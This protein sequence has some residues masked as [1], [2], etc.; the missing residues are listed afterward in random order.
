MHLCLNYKRK[1]KLNYFLLI[2]T[3][4]AQYLLYLVLNI[5][6][7]TIL[8]KID[9]SN[10]EILF[11]EQLLGRME[12]WIRSTSHF[13]GIF[14]MEL[15]K[16]TP[17]ELREEVRKQTP[18][19]SMGDQLEIKRKCSILLFYELSTDDRITLSEL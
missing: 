2:I 16:L 7:N 18:T 17:L 15:F 1:L 14:P 12:W 5:E 19:E 10:V 11:T 4:S 6:F 13:N 3:F 9:Y 8:L